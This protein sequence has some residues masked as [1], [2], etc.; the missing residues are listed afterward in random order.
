MMKWRNEF[1]QG[2]NHPNWVDGEHTDHAALLIK[3]GVKPFC[4]QCNCK[5]RRVL[6]VHHKDGNRH[7]NDITNL[8]FLCYN[9][10]YLIHKGET[11]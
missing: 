1:Q 7:N 11:V 3:V 5:D 2:S 6:L 9:C 10:H 8:I 4:K